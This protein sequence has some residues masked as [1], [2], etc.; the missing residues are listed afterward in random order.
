MIELI[1]FLAII[2]ICFSTGNRILR[3]IFLRAEVSIRPLEELLFSLGLGLGLLSIITFVI[4]LLGGL[5]T[6][7]IYLIL[8]VMG[9]IG[10]KSILAMGK[11]IKKLAPQF[12]NALRS[13]GYL[14]FF[15]CLIL[16]FYILTHFIWVLTPP[17]NADTLHGYLAV[18]RMWVDAHRIYPI[19][20]TFF[21]DMPLNVQMLSI[22][23]LLLRSDYLAQMIVGW[24]FGILVTLGVYALAKRYFSTP[25]AILSAAMFYTMPV[26]RWL[27]FSTKVDLGWAF[28]ECLSLMALL[29]YFYAEQGKGKKYLYL[30]ATFSGLAFGTKYSGAFS[31]AIFIVVIIVK[32]FIEKATVRTWLKE[33][34][35]FLAISIVIASPYYI[36]NLLVMGNPF[37]PMFDKFFYGKEFFSKGIIGY[38]GIVN[39]FRLLFEMSTQGSILSGMGVSIGPAILAYLPGIFLL[40]KRTSKV[41]FILLFSLV[42]SLLWYF[43]RIQRPRHLFPALILLTISSAYAAKSLQESRK[44]IF[45]YIVTASLIFLFIFG[46]T[47]PVNS[48]WQARDNLLPY[49]S[50]NITREEYLNKRFDSETNVAN[51]NSKIRNYINNVLPSNSVILTLYF[52]HQ[53]YINKPFYKDSRLRDKFVFIE[54]NPLELLKKLK[55]YRTT[56]IYLNDKSYEAMRKLAPKSSDNTLLLDESFQRRYLEELISYN[57]QHLYRIVYPGWLTSDEGF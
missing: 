32:R 31:I 41:Y 9:G 6:F 19:E 11:S 43:V 16:L 27:S 39:Y 48:L 46:A 49:F 53:Y 44:S 13:L 15:L 45:T 10:W 55:K 54:R 1:I 47:R 51:P 12:A 38:K 3:F 7:A 24:G 4:G 50:G 40:K 34:T 36:K 57:G 33:V 29:L 14:N 42:Y 23:G 22:V 56:H 17:L 35:M 26:V 8:I 25:V 28:F 18:P 52:C 30:A 20:Y 21:D 5:R 37:F 2:S